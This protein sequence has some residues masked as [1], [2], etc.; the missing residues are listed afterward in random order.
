MERVK[1]PLIETAG[2]ASFSFYEAYQTGCRGG[3]FSNMSIAFAGPRSEEQGWWELA[4]RIGELVFAGN[5]DYGLPV[6][7]IGGRTGVSLYHS[8]VNFFQIWE[9]G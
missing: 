5:N 3:N 1:T 7:G 4:S 2:T 6:G 9:N 8:R